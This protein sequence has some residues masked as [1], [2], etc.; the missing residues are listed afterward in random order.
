MSY[1]VRYEKLG[2][3]YR[4]ERRFQAYTTAKLMLRKIKEYCP[5]AR[6]VQVLREGE[7]YPTDNLTAVGGG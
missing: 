6:I 3:E 4:T 7:H 2:K 1:E 5:K